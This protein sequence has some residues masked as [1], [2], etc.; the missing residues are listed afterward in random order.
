MAEIAILPL[1]QRDLREIWAHTARRWG[2]AQAD[3]YLE[4]VDH[5]ILTLP[6]YPEIGI[7]YAH[8]RPGCTALRVHRHLV[9][10]RLDEDRVEILRVLHDTM[11]VLSRL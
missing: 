10:F 6:R 5:E 9:F 2:A 7:S 4:D 3:R 11:D 8:V 1:A